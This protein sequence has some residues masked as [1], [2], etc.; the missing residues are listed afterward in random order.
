MDHIANGYFSHVQKC[1]CA[2]T[3]LFLLFLH[4]S[5]VLHLAYT[6]LKSLQDITKSDS[7]RCK[8]YRQS[9]AV[10]VISVKILFTL[11]SNYKLLLFLELQSVFYLI[12]YFYF[13]EMYI[14]H[15]NVHIFIFNSFVFSLIRV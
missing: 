14:E 9:K 3:S 7:Y 13:C 10:L 11:H 12:S 8:D 1:V 4:L 6:K 2:Y 5:F 15:S